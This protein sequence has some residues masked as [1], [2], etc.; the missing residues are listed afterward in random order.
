LDS[1]CGRKSS[2]RNVDFP[3]RRGAAKKSPELEADVGDANKTF[4]ANSLAKPVRLKREA[5]AF[6]PA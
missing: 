4:S 1:S 5:M 2:L 6:A 3:V